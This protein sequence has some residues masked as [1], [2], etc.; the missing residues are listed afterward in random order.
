MAVH[1]KKNLLF[2]ILFTL[3][4]ALFGAV[5]EL[6]S[7]Q[8]YSCFMLYAFAVPL[9]MG[10]LPYAL[11]LLKEKYPSNLFLHLWNTA[12][13]ALGVG[14]VFEGVLEIYGTT[15]SLVIVYPVAGG[16]L[17]LAGLAS[18]FFRNQPEKRK[19][20]RQGTAA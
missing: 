14:S 3:F 15:N 16:L 17:A 5:Y 6:F 18:L 9:T 12:I 13:A 19:Y 2:Q 8:V 10:V 11:L 7:H 1:L 20:R 4:L